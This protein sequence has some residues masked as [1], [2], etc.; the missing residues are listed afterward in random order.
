MYG[1]GYTICTDGYGRNDKFNRYPG[2]VIGC[3]YSKKI[4]WQ[5]LAFSIFQTRKST[6]RYWFV[7]ICRPHFRFGNPTAMAQFC[8]PLEC[9]RLVAKK[10]N[11]G[12]WYTLDSIA[13][14]WNYDIWTWT[15]KRI[16][17]E[18]WWT[19]ATEKKTSNAQATRLNFF[20]LSVCQW[21]S[22]I[23]RH[24]PYG[25]C[26]CIPVV[27]LDLRFTLLISI[28]SQLKQNDG[29]LRDSSIN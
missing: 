26:V 8:V 29:I 2:T 7:C 23:G 1:M 15:Q 18:W 3:E 16:Q 9:I 27:E 22:F 13:I 11:I 20:I 10:S 17:G 21:I 28:C 4:V 5:H 24:L 6:V 25:M 12:Q 14:Y 19:V